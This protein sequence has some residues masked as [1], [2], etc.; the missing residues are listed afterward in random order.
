M[1]S[2]RKTV[3]YTDIAA[4][5]SYLLVPDKCAPITPSQL[6][7]GAV[8]AARPDAPDSTLIFDPTGAMQAQCGTKKTNFCPLIYDCPAI[9]Q[10][11][12]KPMATQVD[13]QFALVR[14]S[15]AEAA[16]AIAPALPPPNGGPFNLPD[17]GRCVLQPNQQPQPFA[18]V[19][20]LTS[21]RFN[22]QGYAISGT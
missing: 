18:C 13:G 12:K 15:A 11:D 22:A 10:L 8:V 2:P 7:P 20:P 1:A 3:P 16:D 17:G 6:P 9:S 4:P 14:L 5:L 21:P 19:V